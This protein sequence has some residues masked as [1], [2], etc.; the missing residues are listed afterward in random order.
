MIASHGAPS[1]R[2]ARLCVACAGDNLAAMI[3]KLSSAEL[4]DLYNNGLAVPD[5]PAYLESWQAKSAALR[6]QARYHADVAYGA[7]ARNRIDLFTPE[8]ADGP[9]PLLIFIHGG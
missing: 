3:P 9:R 2:V 4:S 5:Y 6:A 8:P 7:R 1:F